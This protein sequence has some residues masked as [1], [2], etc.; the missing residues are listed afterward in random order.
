MQ[1]CST[2]H[3]STARSPNRVWSSG[4]FSSLISKG[5][6]RGRW[7]EIG[8]RFKLTPDLRPLISNVHGPSKKS[9]GKKIAHR[10][11]RH[12]THGQKNLPQLYRRPLGTESKRPMARESES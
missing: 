6:V 11:P 5:N 1:S 2:F 7:S 12:E 4:S 8:T 10:G 9:S 3:V